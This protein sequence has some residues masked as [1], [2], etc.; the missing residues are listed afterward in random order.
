MYPAMTRLK[1]FSAFVFVFL[2]LVI[3][4]AQGTATVMHTFIGTAD[5]ANPMAEVTLSGNSLYGTTFAGGTFDNGV[6]FKI[7]LDGSNFT[8][9]HHF[10][11]ATVDPDTGASRN[12]DG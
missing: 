4:R 10:S 8:V 12:S 9:L 5:G 6:I 7:N 2:W 11:A 3:G 1:E